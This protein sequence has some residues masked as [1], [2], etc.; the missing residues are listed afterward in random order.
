MCVHHLHLTWRSGP[1]TQCS[2]GPGSCHLFYIQQWHRTVQLIRIRHTLASVAILSHSLVS[3]SGGTCRGR[4]PHCRNLGIF[5]GMARWAE[6]TKIISVHRFCQCNKIAIKGIKSSDTQ[7]WEFSERRRTMSNSF[8]WT[9]LR[10]CRK[11]VW[12]AS[13]PM[14]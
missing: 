14:Y 5:A 6:S 9:L 1:G 4:L 3:Y 10:S 12:L 13:W 2:H 8:K 7:V 11:P